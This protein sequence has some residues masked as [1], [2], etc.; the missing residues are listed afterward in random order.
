MPRATE[1]VIRKPKRSMEVVRRTLDADDDADSE[2]LDVDLLRAIEQVEG[3]QDAAVR[4]YRQGLHGRDLIYIDDV[5]PANFN[6]TMLKHPPYNGG[7]FRVLV[8]NADGTFIK[9]SLIQVE[10]GPK[11]PDV[12]VAPPAPPAPNNNS[13]AFVLLAKAMTD[14]FSKLGEL[15]VGAR[16][17]PVPPRSTQE[18]LNELTMMKTLFDRP[19]PVV[20]A[21]PFDLVAKVLGL[22]KDMPSGGGDGGEPGPMAVLLE[23]A[24]QF[25]PKLLAAQEQAEAIQGEPAQRVLPMRPQVVQRPANAGE[26]KPDVNIIITQQLKFLARQ[27]AK[28]NDPDPYAVMV[29]DNVP[30]TILDSFL[31]RPDWF[32]EICRYV[33]EAQPH[34]EWFDALK[35]CIDGYLTDDGDDEQTLGNQPA[36]GQAD[37]TA[38]PGNGKPD[39]PNS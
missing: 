36:D 35:V 15:I 9:N 12:V 10:P 30:P 19:A 13:E 39:N 31:K 2:M 6:L 25:G 26:R 3:I 28:D 24:K 34:R 11:L 29:L 33:P 16:V 8:C 23:L 4:I 14:G 7:K 17:P 1:T 37:G 20:T 32:E 5:P 22:M 21:D 38:A 18:I 27:A